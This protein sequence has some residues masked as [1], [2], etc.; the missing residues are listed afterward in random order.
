MTEPSKPLGRPRL[1]GPKPQRVVAYI[2]PAY[3][4]DL[5]A[6]ARDNN[7]AVAYTAAEALKRAVD[8][9]RAVRAASLNPVAAVAQDEPITLVAPKQSE[10][11][12]I[13]EVLDAESR[14]KP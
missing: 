14:K 4:D 9:Y 1:P 10:A 6:M 13:Q 8:H 5:K 2:P 11:E 7:R 12:I 3:V